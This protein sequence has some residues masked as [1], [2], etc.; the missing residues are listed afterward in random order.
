MTTFHDEIDLVRQLNTYTYTERRLK[1][2]TVFCSLKIRNFYAMDTHSN[3]IDTVGYFL[4]D[5]LATNRLNNLSILT[6]KNLLHI[7]LYYNIFSYNDDIYRIDRGSPQSIPLSETLSNIYIFVW[8]KKI[9]KEV[10]EQ[11]ELFG[12]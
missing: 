10:Q 3:L 1:P 5:H 4:Q 9:L 12:R 11:H 6:I 8:Q 7:F 2:E